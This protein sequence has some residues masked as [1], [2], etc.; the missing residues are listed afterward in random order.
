[1][2]CIW[3]EMKSIL[4]PDLC[5]SVTRNPQKNTDVAVED[6]PEMEDEWLNGCLM[7]WMCENPQ[8]LI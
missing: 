7:Q 2:A 4:L 3:N 8:Q 6:V 5:L 1:M